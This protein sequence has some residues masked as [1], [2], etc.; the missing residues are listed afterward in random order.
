MTFKI[1]LHQENSE[2]PF[3]ETLFGRFY[4]GVPAEYREAVDQGKRVA[5]H[6]APLGTWISWEHGLDLNTEH[7]QKVIEQAFQ[8]CRDYHKGRLEVVS[9]WLQADHNYKFF[10]SSFSAGEVINL[11]KE[12]AVGLFQEMA[13]DM[14]IDISKKEAEELWWHHQVIVEEN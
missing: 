4:D 11:E 7:G 12:E 6:Y 5:K 3:E 14:G 2:Q 13:A 9:Y 1:T 8:Q 10:S